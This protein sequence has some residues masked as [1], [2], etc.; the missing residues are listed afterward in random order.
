MKKFL[1][2]DSITFGVLIVLVTELIT[3]GLLLLGL[4]VFA[5]PVEE[6]LRW[7]AV[8]FL[9][10]IL[11][12]RYYAKIK[13]CPTTLKSAVSTLFVTFVIFMWYLLKYRYITFS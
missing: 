12:L 7:F 2:H 4:V 10:A 13:E 3:A 5:S 11:M 6:H 9:P 1:N 8:A